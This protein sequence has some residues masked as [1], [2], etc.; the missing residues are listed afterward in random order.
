MMNIELRDETMLTV[1]E[2]SSNTLISNTKRL[3]FEQIKQSICYVRKCFHYVSF[4][5]TKCI[6]FYTVTSFKEFFENNNVYRLFYRVPTLTKQTN[7]KTFQGSKMFFN[8]LYL[9]YIK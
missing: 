5:Q 7:F 8:D 4:L 2:T 1:L 3:F 6:H 9:S